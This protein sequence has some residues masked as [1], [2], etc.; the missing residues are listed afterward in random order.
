MRK[1]TEKTVHRISMVTLIIAS[2]YPIYMGISV[3]T[4]YLANGAV[5]VEEYPKYVIPYTPMCIAL[6]IAVAVY[7]T[8]QKRF[9]MYGLA[10]VSALGVTLFLVIERYFEQIKVIDEQAYFPVDSWQYGLCIATPEVLETIG[11]PAFAENNPAYKMHFYLIMIVI[12]LTVLGLLHGYSRMIRTGN[13]ERK[14]ALV[15]Q[16]VCVVLFIGFCILACFTAFFRNGTLDLSPLSSILTGLFFVLFGV[17][18]GTYTATLIQ[19]QHPGREGDRLTETCEKRLG[20]GWRTWLPA[21][22]A[23]L[24]TIV[25]YIGELVLMGGKLFRFGKGFFFEALGELPFSLC[26]FLIILLAGAV[27][28]KIAD[29][30]KKAPV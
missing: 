16:T 4:D 9:K 20:G 10:A 26:D 13:T 5:S 7:P 3:L 18:F 23:V 29:W 24:T 28:W 1:V 11:L 17:T 15:I 12:I 6:I 2:A 30:L 22:I 14:R 25:M 19:P 27:T 21:V 8:I